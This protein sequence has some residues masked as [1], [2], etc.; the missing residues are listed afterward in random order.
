MRTASAE[1]RRYLLYNPLVKMKVTSQGEEVDQPAVG[2]HR[3]QGVREGHVLRDG[4]PRHPS[5]AEARGHGPRQHGA[6]HQV[7]EE[8]LLQSRAASPRSRKSPTP[9]HDA[10]LFDQGPTKGLGKIRFHDYRPVYASVD[11]PNVRVFRKQIRTFKQLL[12][13][14][15]P[16]QGAGQ[17]HRLPAHPR[18]ALHARR[19]RPAHPRKRPGALSRRRRRS[20]RSS[21]SWCAISRSSRCSSTRRHRVPRGSGSSAGG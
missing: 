10:F 19:L 13:G 11:L 1:D 20:I 17:G 15:R 12:G 3:R 7:H 14:C 6:G 2:H 4:G 5:A 8:L 18:R 16:E 9:R 21:M